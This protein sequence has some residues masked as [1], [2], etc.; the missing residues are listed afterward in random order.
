VCGEKEEKA[1][2]RRRRSRSFTNRYPAGYI[3]GREMCKQ[4]EYSR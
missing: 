1:R 2:V 3:K 4:V